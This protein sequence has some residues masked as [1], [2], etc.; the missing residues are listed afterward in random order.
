VF[1]F[2]RKC[3]ICPPV[4]RS[5][6]TYYIVSSS[7]GAGYNTLTIVLLRVTEDND[8]EPSAWG[9]NWDTLLLG[10]INTG[11]SSSRLGVGRKADTVLYVKKDIVAKFKEVK[12]GSN[13]AESFKE[14]CG[15]KRAALLLMMMMMMMMMTYV[16][17]YC[18]GIHTA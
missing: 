13:L 7:S 12:T 14:A 5:F 9:Y 17:T 2:S 4:F 18:N 10:N 8:M 11:T 1:F 6:T 16:S 15:S 3:N